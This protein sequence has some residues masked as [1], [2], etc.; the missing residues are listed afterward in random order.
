MKT[1]TY[2][3][4]PERSEF[5]LAF[6]RACPEGTF[7]ISHGSKGP[8]W[9][10]EGIFTQDELWDEIKRLAELE[11]TIEHTED[12]IEGREDTPGSWASS[13]LYVLEFEWV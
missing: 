6:A 5:D 13:I 7:A 1:L 3:Q 12:M 10:P 8:E 4:M 11:E 2:L 9:R